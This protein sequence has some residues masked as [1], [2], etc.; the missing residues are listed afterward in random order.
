MPSAACCSETSFSAATTGMLAVWS[1]GVAAEI[2]VSKSQRAAGQAGQKR[3]F[4]GA[5]KE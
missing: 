4:R 5:V 1:T 2:A 3:V